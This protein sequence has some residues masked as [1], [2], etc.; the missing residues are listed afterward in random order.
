MNVVNGVTRSPTFE[1]LKGWVTFL[2]V[3]AFLGALS[4]TLWLGGGGQLGLLAGGI[5]V[6]AAVVL[7][8]FR[9]FG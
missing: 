5:V 4:V 9:N 1:V 6:I 2:T 7:Y 8:S 3:L